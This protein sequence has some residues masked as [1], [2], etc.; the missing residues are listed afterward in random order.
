MSKVGTVIIASLSVILITKFLSSNSD[1]VKNEEISKHGQLYAEAKAIFDQGDFDLAEVKLQALLS[2][3]KRLGT[4]DATGLYNSI[5][6]GKSEERAVRYLASISDKDF[7]RFLKTGELPDEPV[8]DRPIWPLRMKTIL[9]IKDKVAP[10]R[11][12]ERAK[13]LTAEKAE[14]ARLAAEEKA[15]KKADK[16]REEEAKLMQEIGSPPVNSAWDGSVREVERYLQ[17]Y[18]KDPDSLKVQ[19]WGAVSRTRYN[20]RN[21]WSV[22]LIY[23]AK[24]GFGGMAV[25]HQT[26]LIRH[27][28]VV[29]L[30]DIN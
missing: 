3:D 29:E 15:K 21:Y 7:E 1:R 26:A 17:R 27:G 4:Y 24:N 13:I 8:T 6:D 25:A 22:E 11:K 12:A 2:E 23:R 20:G 16:E 9:S 14:K 18:L 30:I 10:L 19:D 5:Q 28:Q